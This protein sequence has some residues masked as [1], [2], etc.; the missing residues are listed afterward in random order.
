VTGINELWDQNTENL[1]LKRRIHTCHCAVILIGLML[2]YTR[3]C[4][5]LHQVTVE[6]C[7][8]CY[9]QLF[10]LSQYLSNLMH[11]ICFTIS[12]ISCLYMFRANVLIIRRSK[13]HYTASGIITPIG[14]CLVHR[15][16]E[17]CSKMDK[18][19]KDKLVRSPRENAGG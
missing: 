2:S 12:F 11:K 17:E 19:A 18:S 16:R 7:S 9:F 10:Y 14:G 5:K 4:L 8:T 13:L 15:L 1:I 3:R 6:L